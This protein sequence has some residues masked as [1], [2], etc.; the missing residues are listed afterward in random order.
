M[1][2]NVNTLKTR[3]LSAAVFVVVLLGL[4]YWNYYTFYFL[5]F[6]VALWGLHEYFNLVEKTDFK[7]IRIQGMLGGGLLFLSLS[8][9]GVNV[10]EQDLFN[11]LIN[12]L[13]YIVPLLVAISF[14]FNKTEK[15]LLSFVYTLS[16]LFY[17]VLPF[18]L[19]VKIPVHSQSFG[20]ESAALSYQYF[21]IMG[22]IFLIWTNDTFA[23]L[24]GSL[25]GKHK[26]MERVSPGKTWE[27]TL[28]GLICCVLVGFLLNYHPTF[29]SRW[30]WP[31]IA[32]LVG[33]F[34][35]IGDLVESLIKRQA[36][37]KDSGS[38]MPGHGGILDR[39]D[40]LLFVSPIVYLVVNLVEA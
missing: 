5:F 36:G 30:V 28:V 3:S 32:L 21:K 26:M 17:V 27:G 7:P 33:I 8:L 35:T 15:P 22:L 18:A 4:I 14:L 19:L 13:L 11:R 29:N 31:M 12:L 10:F 23:Y 1:A 39:F 24:G 16:G 9:K 20:I 25:I 37:V 38:I 6:I 34:G 2:L 40:S